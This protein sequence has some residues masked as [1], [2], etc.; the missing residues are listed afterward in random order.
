MDVRHRERLTLSGANE[1][2]YIARH[3]GDRV[4]EVFESETEAISWGADHVRIATG[5]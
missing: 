1:R 2:L 3:V 4:S 5:D